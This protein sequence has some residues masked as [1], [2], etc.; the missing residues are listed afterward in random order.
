MEITVIS[1]SFNYNMLSDISTLKYQLEVFVLTIVKFIENMLFITYISDNVYYK[2]INH[3]KSKLFHL[4]Q[5]FSNI[6]EFETNISW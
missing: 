6:L 1:F 3:F 5:N 2:L 4:H